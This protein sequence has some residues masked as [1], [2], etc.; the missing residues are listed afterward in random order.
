VNEGPEVQSS[1]TADESTNNADGDGP[2][3]KFSF[4]LLLA[5]NS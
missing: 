5:I 1:D 2:S 3:G 4:G